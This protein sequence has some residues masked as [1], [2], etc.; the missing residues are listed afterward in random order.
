MWTP[1]LLLICVA[2]EGC[3][4]LRAGADVRSY[5]TEA[6]CDAAMMEHAQGIVLAQFGA[7]AEYE[8]TCRCL[9]T[10]A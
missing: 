9:G 3:V 4:V 2:V 6:A 8:A 5:P 1:F 10:A 7:A